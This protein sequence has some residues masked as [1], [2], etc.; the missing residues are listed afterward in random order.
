MSS[1]ATRLQ[2]REIRALKRRLER[3]PRVLAAALRLA[4]AAS[5][6]DRTFPH[7]G[8]GEPATLAEAYQD[9]DAALAAFQ[10]VAGDNEITP[11]S[12][13]ATEPVA[14]QVDSTEPGRPTRWVQFMCS[15]CDDLQASAVD[16]AGNVQVPRD[17][18]FACGP[19]SNTI[20]QLL[21]ERCAVES[22][23]SAGERGDSEDG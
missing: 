17:W 15:A 23:R 19:E 22:S 6:L 8:A 4:N 1:V 2:K 11:V 20:G 10:F 16:Q 13:D 12:G 3:M 9:Y 14:V 7:R 21:C 18:Y 5:R